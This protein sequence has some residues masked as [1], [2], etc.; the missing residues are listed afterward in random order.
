VV[1]TAKNVITWM[2]DA[3]NVILMVIH[4]CTWSIIPVTK[5]AQMATMRNQLP[6]L[7]LLV[8]I[9]VPL[10]REVLNT[11]VPIVLIHTS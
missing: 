9:P 10:A 7:V 3:L 1:P 5:N 11:I 8:M 6:P 4:N 2:T